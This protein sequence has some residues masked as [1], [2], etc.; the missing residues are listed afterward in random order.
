[1]TEAI[2]AS[3]YGG[4][5]WAIGVLPTAEYMCLN[6]ESLILIDNRNPVARVTEWPTAGAVSFLGRI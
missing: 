2:L 1:M 3:L 6:T 5:L 4:D